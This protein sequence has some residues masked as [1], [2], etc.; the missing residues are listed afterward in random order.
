M[1]GVDNWLLTGTSSKTLQSICSDYILLLPTP[2][3]PS[4]TVCLSQLSSP[5]LSSTAP[6][7]RPPDCAPGKNPAGMPLIPAREKKSEYKKPCLAL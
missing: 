7:L 6:A 5:F 3:P 1:Q 2:P 4:H